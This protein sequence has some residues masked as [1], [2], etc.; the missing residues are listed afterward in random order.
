MFSLLADL[1]ALVHG[2]FVVFVVLGGLL[3]LRW[4]RAA[5]MHLPCAAW[6]VTVELTGWLCPLTPLEIWLRGS[7]RGPG[8]GF[9]AAYLHP[10]LYPAG[11][12]P[13]Y[14]WMLAGGVLLVNA[15][16]YGWLFRRTGDPPVPEA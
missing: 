9:L 10:L 2:L 5:W 14:R 6:G 1:V 13:T 12:T 7:L 4:P 16:V 8:R 11:L 15:F 3:V